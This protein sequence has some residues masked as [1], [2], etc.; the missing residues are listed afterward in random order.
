MTAVDNPVIK[1]DTNSAIFKITPKTKTGLGSLFLS[2]RY[3]IIT[4]PDDTNILGN[5]L[6]YYVQN[7]IES[8]QTERAGRF[9][10]YLP[11]I[12]ISYKEISFE[13][14]EDEG[15]LKDIFY[16]IV[17]LAGEM[18]E[19]DYTNFEIL[20]RGF[21]DE[22]QGPFRRKILLAHPYDKVVGLAPERV[23]T[24]KSIYV[25]PPQILTTIKNAEYGNDEL[26]NLRGRFMSSSS[27]GFSRPVKV[28]PRQ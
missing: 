5:D 10:K 23:D 8:K 1:G 27:A 9:V 21:A 7:F 20:N 22:A 28:P 24:T 26:P 13:I 4:K 11:S 6:C 12:K 15:V 17:S 14:R 19:N 18:D 25:R 16:S 2:E 3:D